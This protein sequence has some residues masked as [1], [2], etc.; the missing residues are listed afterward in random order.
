[1][2]KWILWCFM[3]FA[4]CTDLNAQQTVKGSVLDGSSNHEPMIGATIQ[5]QGPKTAGEADLDGN[6][7]ITLPAGTSHI[8]VT[9]VV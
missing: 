2:Y 4:W 1:M 5:G 8:K 6:S 3:L 9:M 7:T